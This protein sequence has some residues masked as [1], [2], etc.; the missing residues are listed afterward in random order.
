ML[1]F[2]YSIINNIFKKNKFKNGLLIS[3]IIL[4]LF[5]EKLSTSDVTVII[6]L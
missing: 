2:L 1:R 4:K 6:S 5:N 3:K